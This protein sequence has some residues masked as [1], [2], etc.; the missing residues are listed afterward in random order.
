VSLLGARFPRLIAWPLVAVG[1]FL[2][3]LGVLRA[4]QSTLSGREKDQPESG[5]T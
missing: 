5:A 1:A 2:G 3:G 4:I